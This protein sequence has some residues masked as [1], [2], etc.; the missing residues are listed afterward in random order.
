M[1]DVNARVRV[2]QNPEPDRSRPLEHTPVNTN[3]RKR[4]RGRLAGGTPV[5]AE[6][7]EDPAI[8]PLGS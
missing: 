2:A 6:A 5:A 8:E 7:E 1:T 4:V 3:R